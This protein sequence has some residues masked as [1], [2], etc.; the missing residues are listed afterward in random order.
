MFG[1]NLR[2]VAEQQQIG[3][4]AHER[5]VGGGAEQA[6]APCAAVHEDAG[7]HEPFDLAAE[8]AGIGAG[9]A[10][11]IGD[12]RLP[13]R[14]EEQRGEQARLGFA[15]QDRC[16]NRQ[17][18]CHADLISGAHNTIEITVDRCARCA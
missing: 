13:L 3:Q 5:T 17:L 2:S 16:Q 6:G 4:R 7:M 9:V 12:A 11:E 10:G 15:A 8:I 18:S 14:D 1:G